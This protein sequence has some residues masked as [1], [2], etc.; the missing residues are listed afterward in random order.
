MTRLCNRSL[1]IAAAGLMVA[2]PVGWASG[3]Q[4]VVP[5]GQASPAVPHAMQQMPCGKRTD[6]V[7]MLREN[8]GE[9][10]MGRGL[11]DSGAVAEVFTS[12]NGTWT[13]VATSP[14]GLSCMI[15]TGQS[16]QPVIARDDTI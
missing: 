10:L 2:L 14:N 4:P 7:R 16:W 3:E 1:L 5:D 13:I 9:G 6:V 11:A 8:F 15:G 12:A